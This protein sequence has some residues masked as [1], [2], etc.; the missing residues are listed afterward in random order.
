MFVAKK[1]NNKNKI[2][3]YLTLKSIL[4]IFDYILF[5]L[6]FYYHRDFIKILNRR[7]FNLYWWAKIID[8]YTFLQQNYLVYKQKQP[9]MIKLKAGQFARLPAPN[10]T[11]VP[12]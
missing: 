2:K 5:Y 1:I 6:F 3:Q 9:G 7:V 4:L 8:V 12:R 11:P 10:K